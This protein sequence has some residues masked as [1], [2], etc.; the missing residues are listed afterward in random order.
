[1]CKSRMKLLRHTII[2]N[3]GRHYT[4]LLNKE[5]PQRF[6]VNYTHVTTPGKPEKGG[7]ITFFN[8]HWRGHNNTM[9]I[10]L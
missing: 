6:A 2:I 1:M 8:S 5:P 9:M 10:T 4:Q 3:R 7:V